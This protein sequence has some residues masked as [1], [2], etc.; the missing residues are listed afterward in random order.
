M[1]PTILESADYI[2]CVRKTHWSLTPTTKRVFNKNGNE[3]SQVDFEEYI[4]YHIR[5]QNTGTDTAFTVRVLDTLAE[6][7]DIN[8][9]EMLS[10]SH[11]YEYNISKGPVLEVL[12]KD[13]LLVDSFKNEPESHGY[14]KFKIKPKEGFGYGTMIPNEAAIYFDFNDPV[15]T[16]EAVLTIM[17]PSSVRDK[18][19]NIDFEVYPNPVRD[20]LRIDISDKDLSKVDEIE[21]VNQLGIMVKRLPKSRLNNINV[22]ELPKGVYSIVLKLRDQTLGVKKFLKM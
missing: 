18:A 7:L 12:F 22:S 21:I 17:K 8:T 11:A 6:E 4:Y 19:S 16:N 10:A 5:F 9:F 13:I 3:V 15:I 20:E 2:E 1:N 14:F